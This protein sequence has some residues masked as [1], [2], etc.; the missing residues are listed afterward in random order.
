V[1]NFR[2]DTSRLAELEGLVRSVLEELGYEFYQD[3]KTVLKFKK[4]NTLIESKY[5]SVFNLIFYF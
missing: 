1:E 2:R 4:K 3:T 5:H